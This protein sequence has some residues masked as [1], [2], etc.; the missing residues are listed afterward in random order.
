MRNSI[1]TDAEQLMSTALIVIDV[2]NAVLDY[3][4]SPDRQPLVDKA[5]TEMVL[6]LQKILSRARASGTPVFF[7]QHNEPPGDPLATNSAGWQIREELT[8]DAGEPVV[9]KASSDSFYD[10]DL[11]ERL[12]AAKIGHLIIGGNATQFCIDTTCRRAVSLGYDV[13]LL[14]DC[15][16]TGDAGDLRFDQIIAHHNATLNGFGAGPHRITVTESAKLL[17]A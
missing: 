4:A 2:Q 6:R 7:V 13:S 17:L 9:Q 8:P 5:Q 1:W 15:H 12:Q 3:S 11:H 10:T 16:M 14:A